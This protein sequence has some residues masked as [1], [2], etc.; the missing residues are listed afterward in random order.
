[1]SHLNARRAKVFK[2]VNRFYTVLKLHGFLVAFKLAND[3]LWMRINVCLGKFTSKNQLGNGNLWAG[4][5]AIKPI[6]IRVIA[7]KLTHP[8]ILRASVSVIIPVK[9]EISTILTF[10]SKLKM[11]HQCVKQIIF[12]DAFSSDGTWEILQD[13]KKNDFRVLTF[14]HDSPPGAARNQAWHWVDPLSTH[15]VFMDVG[16]E[17]STNYIE[18]LVSAFYYDDQAHVVSCAFGLYGIDRERTK[19]FFENDFKNFELDQWTYWLPS[20]RGF[21]LKLIDGSGETIH[22]PRFPEWVDFAGDD[23]LFDIHVRN[24]INKWIILNPDESLVDWHFPSTATAS[25]KVM[26]RYWFG[27]GQTG[28]RDELTPILAPTL[29]ASFRKGMSTRPIIDIHRRKID[30]VVIIFSLTSLGDS[31]GSHRT[32]QLAAAYT[33]MGFRVVFIS[34]TATRE[35]YSRKSWF[36]GDVSLITTFD[37]NDPDLFNHVRM[38]FNAPITITFLISAPHFAFNSLLNEFIPYLEDKKDYKIIYDCI[39]DFSTKY[40]GTNWYQKD[41]EQEILSKSTQTFVVSQ[42]LKNL[43]ET[44]FI[45]KV[46]ISA[47]GFN[48]VLFKPNLAPMDTNLDD[49]K[50]V[51]AG[52]LWGG[53]FDWTNLRLISKIPNCRVEVYGYIKKLRRRLI[54]MDSNVS[55]KGLIPQHELAQ[56]Y[57]QANIL[58]IPFKENKFSSTINPLKIYEYLQFNR[59][60]IYSGIKIP[61]E[62]SGCA[63]LIHINEIFNEKSVIERLQVALRNSHGCPLMVEGQHLGTTSWN[64]VAATILNE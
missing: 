15:L 3:F 54:L 37:I 7:K 10:I 63:H 23:T 26:E 34:L 59:L 49:I 13:F 57:E 53:W 40:L 32:T 33:I 55:F 41:I 4:I 8:E 44:K 20:I 18:S 51:Y 50:I 45:S 61:E 35:I 29:W 43:I 52:A 17:Y 2:Y 62:L 19:T 46:K 48:Q 9:N 21:A 64:N 30:R 27:D 25:K 31:G 56:I 16:C 58:V 39:D 47:N 14:Q 42:N 60:V 11:Q 12:V 36:T 6:Q 24:R 1:M 22:W 28:A 5:S 38:Y